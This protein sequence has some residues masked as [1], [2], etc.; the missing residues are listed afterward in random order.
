[1]NV[2][3]NMEE[4]SNLK[5]A[6]SVWQ[7]SSTSAEL[8]TITKVLDFPLPIY[9]KQLRGFIGQVNYFRNLVYAN[10][11]AVV[12]PLQELLE[13]M[14]NPTRKLEWTDEAKQAFFKI[15]DLISLQTQL[16]FSNDDDLI[17]LLT[18]ASD[19]WLGGF[20]YQLVDG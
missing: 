3:K 18:D 5:S 20:L 16:F 6:N 10:H 8:L 19:Y 7:K 15:K 1:M 14:N 12:K 11:S 13:G 2:S 9:F 4:Y 17:Y